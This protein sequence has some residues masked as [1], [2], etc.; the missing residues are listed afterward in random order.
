M[1]YNENAPPHFHARYSEFEATIEIEC[2]TVMHGELPPRAL[3]LV[4]E[5]AAV[6]RFSP[7][8]P[9]NLLNK[10][11]SAASFG[12]GSFSAVSRISGLYEPRPG[13]PLGRAANAD[14]FQ[15]APSVCPQNSWTIVGQ[16][17]VAAAA[18]P[19]GFSE[20][21]PVHLFPGHYTRVLQRWACV[22]EGSRRPGFAARP[23]H[24]DRINRAG[25]TL[26]VPA[27]GG[28]CFQSTDS[29]SPHLRHPRC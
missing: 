8:F 3:R 9:R 18:F 1:F 14:V 21:A 20:H 13:R 28:W 22:F 29:R 5:W 27:L 10:S 24:R 7:G 4:K 6:H 15:Q 12:R 26:T 11:E 2:L 19:G 23:R 16:P 17:F 25:Q